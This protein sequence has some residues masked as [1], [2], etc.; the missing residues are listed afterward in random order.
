MRED[1]S[2]TLTLLRR[3]KG[4]SQRAA[5]AQLGISQA[6]LSHYE[7]G[8]RE[9]GLNFVTRACDYSG[10]SA[11]YLLGRTMLRDGTLIAPEDLHDAAGDKD[12]R[13]QGSV[14]ALLHKKLLIN[15]LSLLFDLLGRTGDKPL[16]EAAASYLGDAAYVVFRRLYAACGENPDAFFSVHAGIYSLAAVSD[17]ARREALM[18]T[19][20]AA[21]GKKR[22]VL[23]ASLSHDRLLSDYP[24]LG[25]SLLML[26]QQ[27][28]ERM[29]GTLGV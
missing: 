11:D 22:A 8:A 3:E 5:A 9:P 2:R 13:L 4:V 23:P 15:S 17:M 25:Q 19:R 1:F 26:V 27:A 10:G 20:L 7:K 12:N 18:L 14:S 24:Q 21:I 16:I 28:G 6:L 29:S